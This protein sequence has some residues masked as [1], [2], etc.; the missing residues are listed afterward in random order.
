MQSYP[1]HLV[2]TITLADGTAVTLR[3]IRV[4]DADIEQEFVRGLSDEARYYRFMDMLRELSP[5]MLKQMTDIDYH[6]QMALIAVTR[7]SG[8]EVQIAVG[9]YVVFPNGTDCEFA[10]VVSDAWQR[11]GM[12]VRWAFTLRAICTTRANCR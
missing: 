2:K 11:K 8:K 12:S 5:Q 10:I 9:R 4:A 1:A 7:R 6:N 3:P